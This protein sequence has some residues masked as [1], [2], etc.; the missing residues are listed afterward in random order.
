MTS[1]FYRVLHVAGGLLLFFALGAA[2]LA[3]RGE[4]ASKSAMALHG[5][6][7]LVMVVAGVGVWHKD[8]GV[9]WGHWLSAKVGCWVLLA[10]LPILV[11][12]GTLPRML[13]VLLAIALGATAVW[14]AKFKPF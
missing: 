8:E 14:L 7:L 2:L 4:K 3:P 12:K 6:A 1:E 9:E 10:A 13:A 5:V 11:R